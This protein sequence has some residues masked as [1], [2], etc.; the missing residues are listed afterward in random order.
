MI[1]GKQDSSRIVTSRPHRSN[2]REAPKSDD[3][4]GKPTGSAWPHR[5][6]CAESQRPRDGGVRPD[7]WLRSART[8]AAPKSPN[9]Q[10]RAADDI[11][12]RTDPTLITMY[13]DHRGLKGLIKGY[14]SGRA[15]R[16]ADRRNE[17]GRL[18]VGA[19]VG[20]VG[21]LDCTSALVQHLR[22]IFH[23]EAADGPDCIVVTRVLFDNLRNLRD[24]KC[25]RLH[26]VWVEEIEERL[27]QVLDEIM[28]PEE[29]E[30]NHLRAWG[31]SLLRGDLLRARDLSLVPD[32]PL[33]AWGMSLL[34]K[35][36][37]RPAMVQ[38]VELICGL[39]D[40]HTGQPFSSVAELAERVGVEPWKL[41]YLW[42]AEIPLRCTL[43]RMLQWSVLLWAI[44]HWNDAPWKNLRVKP[45]TL[46]RYSQNLAQCTL[47][48]AA[49][50]PALL[51][52]RFDKWLSEVAVE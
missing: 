21:T 49:R 24:I 20:I 45:R 28:R 30:D 1:D 23:L 15:H 13:A 9:G 2:G 4:L 43:E 6:R 41:G 46:Q 18:M 42:R 48:T 10:K 25:D 17:F 40:D 33:G 7:A 14:L 11:A 36:S 31:M 47:S 29:A 52:R 3:V 19:Q 50:D 39:S 26:V 16:I 37:L 8:Q 32:D 27:P 51:R 44:S 22:S 34:R 38:T 5:C 12:A 35:R